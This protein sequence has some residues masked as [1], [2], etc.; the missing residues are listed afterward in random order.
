MPVQNDPAPISRQENTQR[1]EW[2]GQMNDH[3]LIVAHDL[4]ETK[5]ISHRNRCPLQYNA[6]TDSI[7]GRCHPGILEIVGPLA[8]AE[9]NSSI[10]HAQQAETPHEI[11]RNGLD[12]SPVGWEKLAE[13]QNSHFALSMLIVM[14]YRVR[15]VRKSATVL[16]SQSQAFKRPEYRRTVTS[17]PDPALDSNPR[18]S[19]ARAWL[20]V[21]VAVGPKESLSRLLATLDSA[22]SQSDGRAEIV[23][24]T[25]GNHLIDE[26]QEYRN[27]HTNMLIKLHSGPDM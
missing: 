11:V 23:V 8:R 4:A 17:R 25:A 18:Q 2:I 20:S 15:S 10:F 19:V 24:K 5:K 16:Y 1:R 27:S 6:T 9:C 12:A 7:D 21:C 3:R 14:L 13:L 26:I 22:I